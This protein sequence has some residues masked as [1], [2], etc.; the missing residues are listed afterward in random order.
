VV[1]VL[2]A[3]DGALDITVDNGSPGAGEAVAVSNDI[4][5]RPTGTSLEF[6]KII[7]TEI[8]AD[9]TW[10]WYTPGHRI[11]YEIEAV[12]RTGLGATKRSDA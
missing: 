2:G 8:A 10:R 3:P 12:A 7:A 9:T 5:V 6:E 4:V 11:V 1:S